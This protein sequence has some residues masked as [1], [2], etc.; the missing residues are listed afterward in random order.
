MEHNG[1]QKESCKAMET[2]GTRSTSKPKNFPQEQ[3][4]SFLSAPLPQMRASGAPRARGTPLSCTTRVAP[5]CTT[6]RRPAAPLRGHPSQPPPPPLVLAA[7]LPSRQFCDQPARRQRLGGL[8]LRNAPHARTASYAARDYHP[9]PQATTVRN[10][11]TLG[12]QPPRM[13]KTRR[14]LPAVPHSVALPYHCPPVGKSKEVPN[15]RPDWVL[16]KKHT[17]QSTT[18]LGAP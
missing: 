18:C 13:P 2:G 14:H 12:D 4:V 7:T 8:N 16:R 17:Q 5:R 15:P 6:P 10:R 1:N 3:C 9:L 11:P